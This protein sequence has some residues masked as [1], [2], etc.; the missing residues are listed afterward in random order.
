[1]KIYINECSRFSDLLKTE[2]EIYDKVFFN[3][4]SKLQ[5]DGAL[6]IEGEL[7]SQELLALNLLTDNVI[8]V[9]KRLDKALQAKLLTNLGVNHPKTFYD[10]KGLNEFFLT[11][12]LKDYVEEDSFVVKMLNGARGL[13]QTKCTKS[14]LFELIFSN[15]EGDNTTFKK[16][17]SED[18]KQEVVERKSN[19]HR[20]R[21]SENLDYLNRSLNTCNY[22]V[23][24]YVEKKQEFR[25]LYFY[26]C[27]P[28][29]IK[30]KVDKNDW[31]SNSCLT[32][33]GEHIAHPHPELLFSEKLVEDIERIANY[34]NVPWLSID[35]Y[36]DKD[37]NEGIF[38]FQMEFAFRMVNKSILANRIISSVKN[39][40]EN[41]KK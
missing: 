40:F 1:M 12:A 34:L 11:S 3:S 16:L 33:F 35:V 32:G 20:K 24:K 36:V 25:Y 8:G 17:E 5:L 19:L 38:E 13:G 37:G 21:F 15:L 6:L 9:N 22:L 7:N 18:L 39:K 41:L 26:G 28:I 23:Q 31:Q 2:F 30:R 10:L 14:E 27:S 29:V 4:E